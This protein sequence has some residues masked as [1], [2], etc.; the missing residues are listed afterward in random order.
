[1]DGGI[2]RVTVIQLSSELYQFQWRWYSSSHFV[3]L[4]D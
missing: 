2:Y 4:L 3:R 1:M